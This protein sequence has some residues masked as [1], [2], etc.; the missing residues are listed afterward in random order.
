[1]QHRA[2]GDES[3]PNSTLTPLAMTVLVESA[4]LPWASGGTLAIRTSYPVTVVRDACDA[5]IANGYLQYATTTL[6]AYPKRLYAPTDRG[7]CAAADALDMH[8]TDFAR[9]VHLT[10]ARFW[11]LRSAWQTAQEVNAIC[12]NTQRALAPASVDWITFME[13]RHKRRALFVHGRLA[14]TTN[15][16]VRPFYLVLERAGSSP[17]QW[18]RILKYFQAWAARSISPFPP[19]LVVA[20]RA[21]SAQIILGVN[22]MAGGVPLFATFDRYLA[23]TTG[24]SACEWHSLR[25][26]HQIVVADPLQ[27]PPV[28]AA[29]HEASVHQVPRVV[30][31]NCALP[32]EDCATEQQTSWR[33]FSL[34]V[35]PAALG[36][37][38][39]LDQLND[40]SY[41]LLTFLAAHP[42]CPTSTLAEFIGMTIDATT[43][44]L[45]LL[46]NKGFAD[47]VQEDP[48][49]MRWSAHCLQGRIEIELTPELR[50]VLLA[51]RKQ[52]H[53]RAADI[54]RTTALPVALVQKHLVR[55][56]RDGYVCAAHRLPENQLWAAADSAVGLLAAR[57]MEPADRAIQRH[58]FFRADH[59][60]RTQHTRETYA[61]F[62]TLHDHCARRSRASSSFDAAA[63]GADEGVIPFYELVDFES[64]MTAAAWY[65]FRGQARFW[66][67][68]GFGR[69]RAGQHYT[70]FWLEIDG[71]TTTRSR[72]DAS[73]WEDK[74]GRM[75]DYLASDHWRMRHEDFPR[76][77]IVSSAVRQRA[78]VAEALNAVARARGITAPLVF[79]TGHEALAQ[80]GP[81]GPIWFQ[82]APATSEPTYAFDGVAPHVVQTSSRRR[83]LLDDLD[84]ATRLGLIDLVA[85]QVE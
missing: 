7:L 31:S 85:R 6:S 45:R 42:V 23:L 38:L 58:R 72:R 83:S 4:H 36:R 80:R 64:E 70:S 44:H 69:L 41:H 25:D 27:L 78:V 24:L 67:P 82:V 12:A 60:R 19:V 33:G 49:D 68:D 62:E 47:S 57:G 21:L 56:E 51:V 73:L 76:L 10:E 2:K 5:L 1:M 3:M 32:D 34:D 37:L 54:A 28:S 77:L 46:Q 84:H 29:N 66:R 17:W 50:Y 9:R 75:G 35:L 16:G 39:D 71:T 11:A 20:Q 63:Q 40:A 15:E 79:I 26:D 65:V 52:N 22:C 14:V 74:L 43:A 55:L 30:M 13:R 48:R 61:F 18:Y 81:L 53:A 8:A 59:T